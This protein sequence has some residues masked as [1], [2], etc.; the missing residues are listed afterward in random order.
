MPWIVARSPRWIASKAKRPTPWML[1][2]VSVR[3]APPIRMPMSR[4]ST[5]MTGVIAERTPWRRITR[6]SVRPLARAVRM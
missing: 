3:I 1:K 6:R 4:P 2:T 5:V